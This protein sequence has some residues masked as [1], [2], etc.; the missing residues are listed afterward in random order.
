M[1]DQVSL[2]LVSFFFAYV[3]LFYWRPNFVIELRQ[4]TRKFNIK[5]GL[6]ASCVFALLVMLVDLANGGRAHR[7]SSKNFGFRY[8]Y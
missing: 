7:T 8:Y 2:F 4:E 1:L 6:M 5:T 3:V